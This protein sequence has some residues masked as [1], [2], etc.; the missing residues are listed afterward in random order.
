MKNRTPQ[1]DDWATP[2]YFYEKLNSVYNF[3]FDPF[4]WMNDCSE[5]DGLN[6]P[7]GQRNYVNPPYST[8]LK[9]AAIEKAYMESKNGKFSL[10]LIPASTSTKIFHRIIQPYAHSI[11]FLPYR[12]PF[13]GVTEKGKYANWHL[14]D[15]ES[16][17]GTIVFR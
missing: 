8:K 13:I 12:I 6:N 16:I 17:G 11:Y 2:P 5:W 1:S 4:P 9:T 15:R 7:W 14:W 10:M 3:D